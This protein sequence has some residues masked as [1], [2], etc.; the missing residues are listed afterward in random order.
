MDAK[1]GRVSNAKAKWRNQLSQLICVV[2]R[3]HGGCSGGLNLHHVAEGS[4]L[5]SDWA[6]VPLCHGHHDL[7]TL[8]AALRAGVR[9]YHH[10]AVTIPASAQ[11]TG[12]QQE[13]K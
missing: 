5:R 11:S 12:I 9:Q 13:K 1:E 10:Y 4:G 6:L 2:G 7:K 8:A 3:R